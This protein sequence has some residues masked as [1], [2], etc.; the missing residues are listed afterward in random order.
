M[1]VN[2]SEQ[3]M[4]DDLTLRVGWVRSTFAFPAVRTN[5]GMYTCISLYMYE[6]GTTTTTMP[7]QNIEE[8][9]H[10]ELTDENGM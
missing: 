8:M 3:M 6:G 7:E 2:D 4:L 5:I 9:I 10:L 1:T